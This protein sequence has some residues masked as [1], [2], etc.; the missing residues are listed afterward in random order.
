MK[1][2][3]T[4]AL[5]QSIKNHLVSGDLIGLDYDFYEAPNINPLLEEILKQNQAQQKQIEHLINTKK[6]LEMELSTLVDI[7]KGLFKYNVAL[8]IEYDIGRDYE[9]FTDIQTIYADSPAEAERKYDLVNHCE[10][11]YAK[12]LSENEYNKIKQE[13]ANKEYRR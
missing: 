5:V 1:N 2:T 7:N 13:E 3:Y 9:D 11:Y 10:Y 4:E 12:C 8:H 6:D